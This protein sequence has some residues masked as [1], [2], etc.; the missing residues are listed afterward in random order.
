[1]KSPQ[2][3]DLIIGMV[4]FLFTLGVFLLSRVHQLADSNYSM[5]VS[6]SLLHHRSF[7]LDNYAIPRSDLRYQDD[8]ITNGRI[9]QLELIRGHLYY[10]FP[11][12]SSLL[13]MPYVAVMNAIGVSAANA[14]GTY[15]PKGEGRIE[16]SLAALLMAAAAVITFCTSRLLLPLRLSVL[17]ALS[18]AFGTQIWSTASRALWSDTWGIFLIALVILMLLGQETNKIRMR[19]V[20]LASLLSWSYFVRPTY[21]LPIVAI[22]IYIFIYYRSM[23]VLY[24]ATGALWFAGFVTYSWRHFGQPL[25]SYYRASRLTF[26][27]F[28]IALTGNLVSPSRGLLIYVPLVI[29]VFYLLIRYAKELQPRLVLLSLSIIVAHLVVISGVSP[30]WAGHCFGARYASGLVPWFA[31]LGILGLRARSNWIGKHV[32]QEQGSKRRLEVTAGVLLLMSSIIINAR[33]ATTQSTALWNSRPVNVDEH[34]ERVWDWKHPQFL[35]ACDRKEHY[36][37]LT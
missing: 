11:P 17:V 12:G 25:P 4:I 31:L 22:S 5:L 15:N 18:T 3:A 29:F 10:G 21:I 7:A 23:F 6:E 26:D 9:Y 14:D 37:S 8:R 13:S 24:A 2:K 28:W 19:P 1:M 27:T 20:V 34:P 30:W 36:Y 16:F 33:G 32:A 35:S